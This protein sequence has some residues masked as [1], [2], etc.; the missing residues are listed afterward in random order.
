MADAAAPAV[1]ARAAVSDLGAVG[2]GV[3]SALGI[4]ALAASDGGYF[5][6][7]WGWTALL[8][9]WLA[10]AWLLLGRAEVNGGRLGGLFLGAVTVLAGWTWLSLAWTE[11]ATQT[12]L[13][14]FRLLGYLGIAAAL[15]LV[16]RAERV[17]A[18][19]RGTLAALALVSIYGLATRLFPDRLGTYDPVAGYRLSD[20]IG[21][22]N[23]LGIF[24]AMGALLALVVLARDR[25]LVARCLA[26]ASFPLLLATVYFTFS[27]GAWIALALGFLAAFALDSR[28]LHLAVALLVAAVPGGI[29]VFICSSS[30][31]LTNRDAPLTD[32][33]QQGQEV[34]LLLALLA[35]LGAG[36]AAALA[37]AERR[38]E[39]ARALRTAF[40][41]V[42]GVAAAAA[43]L[44]LFVRFGGPVSLVDRAYDAFKAAPPAAS[45]SADLQER[46]FTFTG[47]YRVE[48][49]TAAWDDFEDHPLLGSGPGTYEE[50]WNQHRPIAHDVRDA[51]SLYLETLAELGP[52][53]LALLLVALA[54]P[55]VAAV[56]ARRHPLAPGALA[57]YV[58]FLAHA[59]VDWDWELMGV[60]APALACAVALIV[61]QP[62]AAPIVPGSRLRIGVAVGAM[63]LAAVA[64]VGLVGSNA[65]AASADA[66]NATAPDYAKVEREARKAKRWAPWS[67]EPWQ[68]L[69]EAQLADGDTAAA[70][71]SLQ[72]AIDKEPTDWLLWFHLAEA[73]TGDAKRAAADEAA[74]LNPLNFDVQTMQKQLGG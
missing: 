15:V 16:V 26:G 25:N 52:I 45:T 32:A 22:W 60:T 71:R 38:F 23:G 8:T 2:V 30:D 3:G 35:L 44:G 1:R 36:A 57:T 47:G 62:A 49:W 58:A 10:A 46:L 51:H 66:A 55:L 13:E 48:L 40:A 63:A 50:Y 14:G 24:A 42:L 6:T 27:R 43:V 28:R 70:R 21:Y 64:F 67:S 9:L 31:A 69:G 19:L 56:P 33:V 29:A 7:A 17:T 54:V 65:L 73:S 72:K 34:A 61:L 59:G 20:P 39:P 11:N 12:A 68:E 18:L 41:V 4:G 53:G 37:Y 5:P 74:R